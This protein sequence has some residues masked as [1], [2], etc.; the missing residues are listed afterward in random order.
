MAESKPAVWPGQPYPLGATWD[1]EGVNFALYS[2]HAEKVE[3]CLFD[4]KGRREVQ[5]I[6][7][8]ERTH[9]VWHCYLPRMRPGLLYGYRVH[10][11]YRPEDGHRFNANK[12]LLDPYAKALTGAINWS[13]AHFGYRVGHERADLSFDRR[14]SAPGMPRCKV[15]DTAFTWGDDR[16]P[17][18]PWHDTVIY[19]M[20]V[21]GYTMRHPEVAPAARGTYA[22]LASPPII[23]Y[24]RRLGITTVE[25]MPVH[26]FVDERPLVRKGLRNYW[27]YNSIGYLSPESRYLASGNIA[28]FKTM[29]KALH[30]AGIEVVIDVVYNHTGE[31]NEMGPTLAFR[32]IDNATYYRLSA[33]DRRYYVDYTGC[34]NT[35]N[36]PCP[37]VL[38]LVMD[39]LRYWVTEMHVDGFRFDLTSTLAR[40]AHEFDRSGSFLDVVMQDPVLSQ[41]KLIAE[42]WDLGEGGYQV[43]RFPAGWGE[44]ND[45]YRDTMRAYWKGDEGTIGEFAR[46]LTGSSDLYEHDGRRPFASVNHVTAHDGF[47]LHDLVTYNVKHNEA[48]LED[49]RD[50]NPNNVSWNCG[51]EGEAEDAAVN[52]LRARQQRNLIATLLLSQGV[53][54][55]LAGDEIDHTQNG[56]NNAY[57]QDNPISWLDWTL[58]PRKTQLREFVQRMIRLRHEHAIFRRQRFFQGKPMRA[59]AEKDILWLRPDGTEM[60]PE[61][62]QRP[63]ARSLAVYL[64]GEGFTETDE[65]GGV[66]TGTTFLVLFNAYHDAVGFRLPNSVPGARW[67]IVMDT[68]QSGGLI[69]IGV[70]QADAT[71]TLGGRALA[72]LQQQKAA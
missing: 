59:A 37:P 43:G 36:V 11:P 22:G 52:A 65:K 30:S 56:N 34:G 67:H 24:L 12:L 1:G 66:I 72:L 10:G 69:R 53:P 51:V 13:D 32:G 39:S 48:N 33:E 46:R 64:S 38:R 14:D 3:L 41:V 23:D 47:T 9:D 60:T 6:T 18:V 16:R 71:Y 42:P 19:E 17:N 7:V 27:G 4:Q 62:W 5:R 57:C 26:A 63:E 49:N 40:E 2:R 54:M 15:V 68:A 21:R 20:H 25:L 44:W 28:E 61:E 35:F 55:L 50:G 70:L 58:T 8:N 29:V 45:R 31:G